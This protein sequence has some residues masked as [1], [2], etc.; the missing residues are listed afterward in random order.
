[1]RRVLYIRDRGWIVWDEVIAFG[2]GPRTTL[3]HFHPDVQVHVDPSAKRVQAKTKQGRQLI[4]SLDTHPRRQGDWEILRGLK[5]PK[6][7]GWYSADFNDRQPATEVRFTQR[8]RGPSVHTWVIAETEADL[9]A[10]RQIAKKTRL[11]L[12]LKDNAPNGLLRTLG[13]EG[14]H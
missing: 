4:L 10:L 3:W 6:P 9:A 7:A 8:K 14:G 5:G 13:L 2:A 1:M 11:Q 12:P